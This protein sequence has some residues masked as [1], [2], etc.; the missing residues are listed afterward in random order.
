MDCPRGSA[1]YGR[2]DRT[3]EGRGR[4]RNTE[5]LCLPFWGRRDTAPCFVFCSACLWR[6]G[7]KQHLLTIPLCSAGALRYIRNLKP[8]PLRR[9]MVEKYLWSE[10]DAEAVCAFLEPMLVVDHR[11]RANAR[12]MVDH[13]WLQVDPLSEELWGW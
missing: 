5:A 2:C 4:P 8:W 13:P 3:G 6:L 12:D 7:D 11:K 10:S 9:V 1:P